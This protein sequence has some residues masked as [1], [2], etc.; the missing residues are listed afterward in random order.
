MLR[1]E[2]RCCLHAAGGTV[3]PPYMYTK[4]YATSSES[5][6]AAACAACAPSSQSASYAAG[7]AIYASIVNTTYVSNRQPEGE[8]H[9]EIFKEI[10]CKG[11]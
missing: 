4:V 5:A 1:I 9:T 6:V 3:L 2:L 8:Y 7:H 11:D 10:F